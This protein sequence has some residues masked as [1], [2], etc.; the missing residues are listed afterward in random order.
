MPSVDTQ[1]YAAYVRELQ[2]RPAASE[3]LAWAEASPESPDWGTAVLDA[4]WARELDEEDLAGA[5]E[6]MERVRR[7]GG[8]DALDAQV[9]LVA[10]L[11]DRDDAEEA[12]RADQ[13]LRRALDGIAAPG[14]KEVRIY[15]DMEEVYGERG[16]GRESLTWCEAALERLANLSEPGQ[17]AV[18]QE[19][20]ELS[21]G[22]RASRWLL[23]EEQGMEPFEEDRA[24][25][26]RSDASLT[27]FG[28]EL[29]A[30][31][32]Q[33]P[34]QRSVPVLPA[35]EIPGDGGPF[36][37]IVLRWCREDFGAVRERWPEQTASY[38][39]GY[40]NYAELTQLTARAYADRGAAHV[41]IVTG[42]LAEFLAWTD[43]EGCDPAEA[44]S[45]SDFGAWLARTRPEAAV[46]FPPPRN[47]PC[48]CDSGRKYKKCCGDPA[49][50]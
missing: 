9:S 50:N 18:R 14:P 38:G 5:L 28:G 11:L 27:E 10:L 43:R 40:A 49:R 44:A 23:R 33:L 12:A 21:D 19:W 16:L 42:A 37:G 29:L 34:R 6:L 30:A 1:S 20:E 31:L 2:R 4:A 45:R 48:W 15:S 35:V 25:M 3:S 17:D 7:R 8:L 39:D 13:E 47:G 22:F 32:D 24:A 46:N 36:D 41:L 26:E